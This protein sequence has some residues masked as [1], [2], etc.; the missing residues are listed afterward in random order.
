MVV[1]RNINEP[2]SHFSSPFETPLRTVHLPDKAMQAVALH[3]G[4]IT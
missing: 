3:A 2:I 4:N 1:G